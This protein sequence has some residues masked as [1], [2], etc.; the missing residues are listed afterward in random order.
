MHASFPNPDR[1]KVVLATVSKTPKAVSGRYM[2][3][4]FASDLSDRLSSLNLPV[5]AV[6]SVPAPTN[7]Q[8]QTLRDSW[9]AT[10]ARLPQAKI[11]FFEASG[12]FLTEDSPEELDRAV[13][14]FLEGK[15]VEGKGANMTKLLPQPPGASAPLAPP[16]ESKPAAPPVSKPPEPK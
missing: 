10:F 11:A 13:Q 5:L 16:T 14:Q 8:F 1:A 7:S 4:Y 2:L 3:E 15:A 6:C 12:E 9:K